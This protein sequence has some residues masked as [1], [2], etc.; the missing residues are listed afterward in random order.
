MNKEEIK[1]VKTENGY[2]VTMPLI[3]DDELQ[4][5]DFNF[6]SIIDEY[7]KEFN[8]KREKTIEQRLIYDLYH[9]N[10]QLKER[11]D[12]AI[13]ILESIDNDFYD[14]EVERLIIGRNNIIEL[15]D[16]LK[17]DSNENTN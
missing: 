17:G 2:K 12:K 7:I 14:Y 1:Y 9:E 16:I 3:T 13:E 10:K 4:K 15:L 5:I 11:I 8:N 6:N